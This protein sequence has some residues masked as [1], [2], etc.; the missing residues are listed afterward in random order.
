VQWTLPH[1]RRRL[2]REIQVARTIDELRK[3]LA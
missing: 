3:A 1:E 2:G